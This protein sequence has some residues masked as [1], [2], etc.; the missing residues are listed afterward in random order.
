MVNLRFN[1]QVR[2]GGLGQL[3]G[4]RSTI[5]RAHLRQEMTAPK[6]RS[7]YF[8]LRRN[9]RALRSKVGL[10]VAERL[11]VYSSVPK[12]V[13]FDDISR[14]VGSVFPFSL[15]EIEFTRSAKCYKRLLW[16]LDFCP[17]YY[18]QKC[19]CLWP[20]FPPEQLAVFTTS[21]FRGFNWSTRWLPLNSL[22][23][24]SSAPTHNILKS[25]NNSVDA[26]SSPSK[27]QFLLF[28]MWYLVFTIGFSRAGT[29]HPQARV[30]AEFI[31]RSGI[32][33]KGLEDIQLLRKHERYEATCM[34]R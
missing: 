18:H 4:W 14:T 16:L 19:C 20:D 34:K 10:L 1:D 21:S 12:I 25:L 11:S 2:V 30:C 22:W 7:K 9:Q 32:S 23:N 28:R 31:L 8:I 29:L 33:R 24:I 13:I 5:R 26:A 27:F 17:Q 15:K 3:W 6:W